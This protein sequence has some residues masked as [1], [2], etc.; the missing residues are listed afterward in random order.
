MTK[1]HSAT[2][3]VLVAARLSRVTTDGRSRI[4]Q[5][6]LA[7]QRWAE[8][9]EGVEIVGISEDRGISGAVS[10]FERRA[11]GPW[12]TDPERIASY[13]EIVASKIDRLGR[14]SRDM[15]ALQEWA[16]DHG[17]TIRI[18]T[19]DLVWP[20]P[21]GIAGA[22]YQI[23]WALLGAMAQIELE[24]ITERYAEARADLIER[25]A[26]VG[27]P[28]FGFLVE[29][30]RRSKT[31]VPDPA[32]RPILL[33]VIRRTIAGDTY[34]SICRYLDEHVPTEKGGLWAPSSLR[35]ILR[36]P[37][38]KGKRYEGK[39]LVLEHKGLMTAAEWKDL[40]KAIEKRPKRRGPMRADSSLLTGIIHCALCDGR[41]YRFTSPGAEGPISYYRCKGP[42]QAPST[43]RNMI[44]LIA[45][46]EW[47]VGW[48]TGDVFGPTEVMERVTVNGDGH[49]E[50]IAEIESQ[51]RE[52]DFDAPDYDRRHS[53]LMKER[54]R[55][56]SLPKEPTFVQERLTGKTV[57]DVWGDLDD[58]GRRAYMAATGIRVMVQPSVGVQGESPNVGRHHVW[59]TGD[60]N[61]I[62]ASLANITRPVE[63]KSD[64]ASR[65]RRN[66]RRRIPALA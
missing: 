7:A 66:L 4:E 63:T 14:N 40:Q 34:S 31:L 25:G 58:D 41:M 23:Q 3:R 9:R 49:D 18:I 46:E 5:D 38:L 30:E 33:E 13:D 47:V 6:D 56:Q 22:S 37:A 59:M 21:K 45:V 61:Q 54:K 32:L 28:P 50:E 62:S 26:L 35:H 15:H 12:L 42:A 19:P 55:L 52:L 10:P 51:L 65:L 2:T 39:R 17:K 20:C 16:E 27:R 44:P 24:T 36:S 1:P 8:S 48:F 60:V 43:C 11:L 29:G 53:A 57:A 64:P